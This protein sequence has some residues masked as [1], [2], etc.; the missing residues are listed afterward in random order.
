MGVQERYWIRA[1]VFIAM[2]TMPLAV[3]AES[4][5]RQGENAA[6]AEPHRALGHFDW[7]VRL[8][9]FSHPDKHA[10]DGSQT[11]TVGDFDNS[12]SS[13]SLIK[14]D[15]ERAFYW[16]LDPDQQ[17]VGAINYDARPEQDKLFHDTAYIQL[18]SLGYQSLASRNDDIQFVDMSSQHDIAGTTLSFGASYLSVDPAQELFPID[19]LSPISYSALLSDGD[20]FYTQ[21]GF[22]WGKWQPWL[23]YGQWFSREQSSANDYVSTQLGLTY[24]IDGDNAKLRIGIENFRSDDGIEQD[25][26]GDTVSG[27]RGELYFNF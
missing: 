22:T 11:E 19:S 8:F 26:E 5:T 7:F 13:T 17:I 3:G 14:N 1:V 9:R 16:T 15:R 10:D 27:V 20:G 12:V 24:L 2:C 21:T 25:L 18:E 4:A 6:P 23:R